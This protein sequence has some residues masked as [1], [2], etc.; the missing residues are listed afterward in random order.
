MT[1]TT[2]TIQLNPDAVVV[3]DDVTQLGE[4][5]ARGLG[6]LFASGEAFGGDGEHVVGGLDA[7]AG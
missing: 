6:C 5:S 3:V 7:A 2:T 4:R 1:T